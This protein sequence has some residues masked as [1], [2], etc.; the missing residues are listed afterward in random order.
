MTRKPD[1]DDDRTIE[2]LCRPLSA[3]VLP[4]S[5]GFTVWG[6]PIDPERI[7]R[8]IAQRDRKGNQA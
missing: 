7:E 1:P 6:H 3:K 2:E 8:V 5:A 4:R